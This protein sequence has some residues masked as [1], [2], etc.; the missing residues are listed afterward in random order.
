MEINESV[1]LTLE[2]DVI[3]FINEMI[4]HFHEMYKSILSKKASVE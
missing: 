4:G 2:S 1:Y 3:V